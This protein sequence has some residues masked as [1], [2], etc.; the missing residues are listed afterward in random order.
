MVYMGAEPPLADFRGVAP[1]IAPD[2]KLQNLNLNY[3]ALQSRCA[4]WPMSWRLADFMVVF[5]ILN[6]G[7]N[8]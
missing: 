1:K 4:V 3:K 8:Y 6:T 2:S 7:V 5:A